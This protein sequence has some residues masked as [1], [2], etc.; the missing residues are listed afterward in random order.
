MGSEATW[1]VTHLFSAYC[2]SGNV[3]VLLCRINPFYAVEIMDGQQMLDRFW[4]SW[5]K[6]L[7][8]TWA[9]QL[10]VQL[11][12]RLPTAHVTE[13]PFHTQ[14]RAFVSAWSER[15]G[16]TAHLPSAAE[17]AP[18]EKASLTGLSTSALRRPKLMF[19]VHQALEFT[20]LQATWQCHWQLPCVLLRANAGFINLP[21]T[22]WTHIDT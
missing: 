5:Q 22:R 2:L 21:S 20:K 13:N 12:T 8:W 3:Q 4:C 9:Q 16:S 7:A 11:Q 10:A 1:Q 18:L 14:V 15:C 6:M 19:W 17:K